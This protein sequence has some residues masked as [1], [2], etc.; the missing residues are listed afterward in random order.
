MWP[1]FGIENSPSCPKSSQ[2]SF[3]QR[4]IIF[5]SAPKVDRYSS[6]F[7][8]Q[9]FAKAFRKIAQPGHTVLK[10][11]DQVCINPHLNGENCFK[12][13]CTYVPGLEKFYVVRKGE[14]DI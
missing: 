12:I 9:Y 7:V 10:W 14:N 13:V 5:Q 8:S 6:L 2:R 1:D 11:N 3:S 4:I